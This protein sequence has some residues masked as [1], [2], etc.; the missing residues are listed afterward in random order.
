MT[1][2]I[3]LFGGPGAGKS[4]MAAGIFFYLKNRGI[5]CELASEYAKDKVWEESY[6]VLNNQ[7]YVFGKQLHRIQR[8]IDKVD[9]VI[10]DAPLL[11]SLIYGAHEGKEFHKLV[12]VVFNRFDNINFFL[13]RIKDF[14]PA[15]RLQTEDKAKLLDTAIRDKLKKEKVV[16]STHDAVPETAKMIS[17]MYP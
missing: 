8:L 2:V 3:N 13:T 15:G 6:S 16:F 4:T 12:K 5:N 10:T 11:F 17:A 7:I 1:K 9:V 14:N